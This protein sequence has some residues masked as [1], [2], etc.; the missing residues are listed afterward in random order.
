M[1]KFLVA[2]FIMTHWSFCNLQA[3]SL[4][5]S[6]NGVPKAVK[7]DAVPANSIPLPIRVHGVNGV[8]IDPATAALQTSQLTEL[9]TANG[10]LADIETNTAATATNTAGLLTDTQLRASPVPISATNLDIRDLVF[11]TDKVDASG[12]S[13]TVTGTVPLPTG[14]ATEATLS[15]LNAKVTAVDTGNVTISAALPAG[16]NVIGALTA[17]Q[18]VNVSQINGVTPLMGA[19]NTG[20]GSQRVTIATDQVAIATK[21]PVNVSGSQADAALTATTASTAT[22]PSNAVGVIIQAPD[23]NTDN[24]RY[25]IG[26]TASTT[27]GMQL[28]P[29]RDSGYIPVA[30]NVSICAEVSGT[31]AYQIQWILSQ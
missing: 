10:Y 13:V 31:N 17:N 14:A 25:R 5:F 26:G 19:G 7:I 29:G 9:Q 11:A 16:A 28:Q 12:S 24:I 1:K 23:T 21:D 3:A 27:A 4:D 30:A 15:A 20:T 22:V 8:A 18:S 6:V 2:L